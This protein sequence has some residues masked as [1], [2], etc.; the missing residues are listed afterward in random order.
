M[1]VWGVG[2]A[3]VYVF[4]CVCACVYLPAYA[5]HVCVGFVCTS[6]QVCVCGANAIEE[7]MS[8]GKGKSSHRVFPKTQ[9]GP[10]HTGGRCLHHSVWIHPLSSGDLAPAT[11]SPLDPGPCL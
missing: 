3:H 8:R 4:V 5:V 10:S 6:V 1:C 9:A 7:Q 2:Q 11:E